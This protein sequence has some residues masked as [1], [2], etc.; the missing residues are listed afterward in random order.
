MVHAY[1]RASGVKSQ[2]L[3]RK[4]GRYLK[5]LRIAAG[6]TQREVAEALGMK[7]YTFVSQME[8]G[9]GRLPTDLYQDF[10]DV[11]GIDVKNLA[12]NCL[13]FWDPYTYA[14]LF[15]EDVQRVLD[16][17]REENTEGLSRETE[18]GDPFN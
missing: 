13:K 2:M 15:K 4:G 16:E 12:K 9:K 14:A 11:V 5:E 17:G 8:A 6:L 7:H 10:A 18:D 3:R 1:N